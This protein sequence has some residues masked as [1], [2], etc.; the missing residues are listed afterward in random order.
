MPTALP[1]NWFFATLLLQHRFHCIQSIDSR[2]HLGL[3]IHAHCLSIRNLAPKIHF[4]LSLFLGDN[5]LNDLRS[6][7]WS[8]ISFP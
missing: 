4:N 2:A 3:I 8:D 7:L 6:F 5:G 1:M